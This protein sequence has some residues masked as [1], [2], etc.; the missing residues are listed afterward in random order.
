MRR[1]KG[2]SFL[3]RIFNERGETTVGA[4]PPEVQA[5]LDRLEK[6][7]KDN[8]S[9]GNR[10]RAW[11]NIKTQL[12]ESLEFDQYGNP[13]NLVVD[14][15]SS[16]QKDKKAPSSYNDANPWGFLEQYAPEGWTP[17][18]I[19][20]YYSRLLQ[21][22]GYLTVKQYGDR[23]KAL[24]AYGEDYAWNCLKVYDNIRKAEAKYPWLS[25]PEDPKFKR[26]IA[27][28]QS[29]GYGKPTQESKGWL[30]YSWNDLD[31]LAKAARMANS[32]IDTEEKER[33]GSQEEAQANQSASR[34]GEP[35]ASGS[36]SAN[37]APEKPNFES[38]ERE[39][40]L[41]ALDKDATTR[42]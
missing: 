17:Q 19:D 39:Q 35:H 16:V 15:G 24:Q 11:D 23:E 9:M 22:Q 2:L 29:Q 20:D 12:G 36:G 13:V 30:D 34:I 33:K 40:I 41:D 3:L 42:K 38:M 4:L 8:A 21:S 14:N 7:E 18:T 26:T 5:K 6:L 25:Q 28:I 32:E 10:L 37:G 31:G 1:G 27:V